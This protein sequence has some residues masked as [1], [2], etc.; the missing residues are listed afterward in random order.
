M[1]VIFFMNINTYIIYIYIVTFMFLNI[2][3]F[4]GA[5]QQLP[6]YLGPAR[7]WQQPSRCHKH[8]RAYKIRGVFP[9]PASLQH[10]LLGRR[11]PPAAAAPEHASLGGEGPF[12]PSLCSPL[13]P[14]GSFPH[15][16]LP[17]FASPL[18]TLSPLWWPFDLKNEARRGHNLISQRS[19]FSV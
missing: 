19:K 2:K 11:T 7:S 8:T 14:L 17:F 4:T 18:L 13:P 6:F 1:V 16:P 10:Q 12:L 9:P 5:Q 15:R 3:A